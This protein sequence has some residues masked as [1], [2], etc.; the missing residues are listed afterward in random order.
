M[1]KR[2]RSMSLRS[3]RSFVPYVLLGL[4]LL[5]AAPMFAYATSFNVGAGETLT[6]IAGAIS[7]PSVSDGDTLDLVDA[8]YS[9]WDITVSKDLIIQGQGLSNTTVSAAGSGIV[10][11]IPSGKTVTLRDME[12]R[13]GFSSSG[14]GIGNQGTVTVENCVFLGNDTSGSSALGGGILTLGTLV[15]N[16][17]TLSGNSA[18]GSSASGG[19]ICCATTEEAGTATITNCT[20]TENT[21]KRDGSGIYITNAYG[22]VTAIVTVTNC[23]ICNNSAERYGGGV[24][25]N[26]GGPVVLSLVNVTVANNSALDTCGGV[27]NFGGTVNLKNSIVAMNTGGS[28][29]DIW[30]NIVS[31]DY[32]LIRFTTGGTLSGTTTHNITLQDPLLNVLA[33]NGGPTSTLSLQDFSPA[34]DQIPDAAMTVATDQRGELRGFNSLDNGN[35]D[36]SDMGAF[37]AQITL[38]VELSAFGIE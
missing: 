8:L 14:G 29:P 9:E 18:P 36:Y 1:I 3:S 34:A 15:L 7:S 24:Q 6:T 5:A 35:D 26:S 28:Y 20:F 21:A 27:G 37:E 25:I 31:Q 32:N 22:F 13:E 12:I 23:T 17:S 16:N 33:D 10:F 4:M 30:G 2:N 19:G 11:S 38:P